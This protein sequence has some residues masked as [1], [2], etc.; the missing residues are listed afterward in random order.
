MCSKRRRQDAAAERQRDV[1]LCEKKELAS[2]RRD[3]IE[4]EG[5]GRSQRKR[6]AREFDEAAQDPLGLL[7]YPLL[8]PWDA[9]N[10]RPNRRPKS[11]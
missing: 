2:M 4:A 3:F 8:S 1:P 7:A 10:R 6:I 9:A 11:R 5:G